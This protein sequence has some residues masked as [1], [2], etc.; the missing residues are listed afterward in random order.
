MRLQDVGEP[1]QMWGH[2][3]RVSGPQHVP[4]LTGHATQKICAPGA[5]LTPEN[6]PYTGFPG[7]YTLTLL[8]PVPSSSSYS[9]FSQPPSSPSS[10]FPPFCT[11]Y[12]PFP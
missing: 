4:L 8:L 2:E 9:I 7:L 3:W 1:G 12:V 5:T 11:T 10:S 6:N